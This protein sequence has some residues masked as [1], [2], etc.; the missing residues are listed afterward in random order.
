LWIRILLRS[1]PVALAL[2][3]MG[4][5]FAEVFLIFHKMNG[6]IHDPANEAVR[7]RTPL[8]MAVLGVMIQVPLELLAH[9][10]RKSRAR[11]KEANSA[12]GASV[13]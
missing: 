1:V 8:T 4:Y 10:I 6:G 7:W 2:A 3:V 11:A 13:S 12:S 5:I 9:G